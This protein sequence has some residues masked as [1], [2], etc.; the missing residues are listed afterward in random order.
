MKDIRIK[1]DGN[2]GTCFILDKIVEDKSLFEQK[3]LINTAT[4]QGTDKIYPQ[5]GTNLLASA[6]GGTIVDWNASMHAGNFAATDT[7]YFCTYEEHP[8]VYNSDNYVN[9]FQLVPAVYDNATHTL[10]FRAVFS[11][12]DGTST[13]ENFAISTKP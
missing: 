13:K 10:Y 3:Y 12:K 1:F 6:I 7:I 8:V 11:F 4:S 9:T 2:D 5:R